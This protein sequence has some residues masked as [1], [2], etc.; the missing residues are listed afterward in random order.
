MKIPAPD[1]DLEKTLNS[2]Q[3]FQWE[4]QG[5]GFVGAIGTKA[6]YV[7]QQGGQLVFKGATAKQVASI[8]SRSII[9]WRKS[10]VRSRRIPR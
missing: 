6:I 4:T 3:V 2:G 10:A 1:F 5:A 7:E 8:I 9:R